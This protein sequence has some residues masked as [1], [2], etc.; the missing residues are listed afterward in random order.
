MFIF[1]LL[2][3]ALVGLS[4]YYLTKNY[5]YWKERNVNGPEPKLFVGSYSS[6]YNKKKHIMDEVDAIYK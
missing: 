6:I 3:I 5:T 2:I 1:L 4:Y